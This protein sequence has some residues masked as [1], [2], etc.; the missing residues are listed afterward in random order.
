MDY[1]RYCEI[2]R[3][4]KLGKPVT[5]I[6]TGEAERRAYFRYKKSLNEASSGDVQSAVKFE[7]IQQK[8]IVRKAETSVADKMKSK[9]YKDY[10]ITDEHIEKSIRRGIFLNADKC[11]RWAGVAIQFLK[12]KQDSSNVSEQ[13]IEEM[14]KKRMGERKSG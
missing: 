13:D 4:S 12:M 10:E 5:K 11:P 3:L 9:D 14:W 8:K 6:V 2:T 7:D 1:K